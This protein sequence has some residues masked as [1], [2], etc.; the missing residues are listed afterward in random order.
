VPETGY[1]LDK[2]FLEFFQLLDG[3]NL[4]GIPQLAAIVQMRN[5]N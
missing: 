3:A 2:G 4:V 5:D 1:M